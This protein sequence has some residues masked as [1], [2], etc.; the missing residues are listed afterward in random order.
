[1]EFLFLDGIS[2]KV[3]EI[4]IERKVVLCALGIHGQEG[5]ERTTRKELPSFQLT[6]AEDTEAWQGF[7]AD[8]K[9]RGLLGKNW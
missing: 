8:L 2:S 7:L 1:M 6:E 3:R 9:G 5:G 4:G